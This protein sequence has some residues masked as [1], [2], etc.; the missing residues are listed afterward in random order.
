VTGNEA[1][2]LLFVLFWIAPQNFESDSPYFEKLP[3]PSFKL[4]LHSTNNF[5]EVCA[6]NYLKK[7]F[8]IQS[9]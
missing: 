6:I 4:T 8:V 3:R 5:W 7:N 2:F 1:L 9:D